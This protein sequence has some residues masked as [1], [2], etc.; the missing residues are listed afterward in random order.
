MDFLV[1]VVLATLL[2]YLAGLFSFKVKTRWCASC[3][4]VKSCP[5]CSG[6]ANAVAA[7]RHSGDPTPTRRFGRASIDR[8]S[9]R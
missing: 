7:K 9:T 4:A 1:T 6:W 2:G 3:G 8:A 5:N